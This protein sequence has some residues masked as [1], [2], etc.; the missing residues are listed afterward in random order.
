MRDKELAQTQRGLGGILGAGRRVGGHAESLDGGVGLGKRGVRTSGERVSGLYPFPCG[1]PRG[2]F[3]GGIARGG[4]LPPRELEL[5]EPGEAVVGE[6]C[7]GRR[8]KKRLEAGRRVGFPSLRLENEAEE[9]GGLFADFVGGL[10]VEAFAK[11]LFGGLEFLGVV[12]DAR[13]PEMSFRKLRN[14]D[15]CRF[16]EKFV[17]VGRRLAREVR[18]DF[19]HRL[20]EARG[21]YGGI[22]R[23]TGDQVVPVADRLGRLARLG[24]TETR[25]V[26]GLR[27]MRIAGERLGEGE[28]GAR[29]L[30]PVL[31]SLEPVG[32]PV[33]RVG[34][35]AAVGSTLREH[36]VELD[37][38][39]L[40]LDR[41]GRLRLKP[42]EVVEDGV[43][44]VGKAGGVV[45][46][47]L[48]LS[49]L[50]EN[51]E[52]FVAGAAHGVAGFLRGGERKK[53]V[54][55]GNGLLAL[56][57][58]GEG[59]GAEVGGVQLL[60]AGRFG[61]G[62]GGGEGVGIAP[63]AVVGPGCGETG[64]GHAGVLRVFRGQ[65]GVA[66]GRFGELVH[67][68]EER[69]GLEDGLCADTWR[70]GFRGNGVVTGEGV[71]ARL[72]RVGEGVDGG[73]AQFGVCAKLL[74]GRR[75]VGRGRAFEQLRIA[76]FGALAVAGVLTRLRCVVEGGCRKFRR[77][78]R[79]RS[80]LVK[81]RGGVGVFPRGLEDEAAGQAG[82]RGHRRLRVLGEKLR[83]SLL[84]RLG[85]AGLPFAFCEA[86]ED[87]IALGRRGIGREGAVFGQG[88]LNEAARHEAVGEGAA[89]GRRN[90]LC[91]HGKGKSEKHYCAGRLL[92]P[93]R[94]SQNAT[95]AK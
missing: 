86:V 33:E 51:D 83:A 59:V 12:A 64:I 71:G 2:Q 27:D 32:E 81:N 93:V 19:H 53:S 35:E 49:V 11:V 89:V 69:G 73:N 84:G 4:V 58:L 90:L 13:T 40:V 55:G 43:R 39:G 21:R 46:H 5:G 31:L 22:L 54:V 56:A 92:G 38:A 42:D 48:E 8:G 72:R 15:L 18:L 57:E 50:E 63:G 70:K 47:L 9:E 23:E 82:A 75:G 77:R 62:L 74:Y 30:E 14:L 79:V 68:V 95:G 29:C 16:G 94:Q 17:K 45:K 3:L 85:A 44:R 60:G 78:S 26:E 24:Q 25:R 67:A 41:L 66:G 1:F 10:E 52:A 36:P 34:G 91:L 87:D 37:G 80:Q 7:A 20:L 65:V 76:R 28:V 6:L 88:K 61:R